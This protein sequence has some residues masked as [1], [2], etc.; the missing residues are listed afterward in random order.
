MV[1]LYFVQFAESDLG[2]VFD[3]LSVRVWVGVPFLVCLGFSLVGVRKLQGLGF[4]CV[5]CARS[6]LATASPSTPRL[7]SCLQTFVISG[8]LVP[9][10]ARDVI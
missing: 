6:P 9:L 8:M 2:F 5:F 7:E 4:C 1:S 10:E 3:L